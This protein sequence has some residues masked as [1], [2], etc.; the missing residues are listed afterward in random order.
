MVLVNYT[1]RWPYTSDAV[2]EVIETD[3]EDLKVGDIV[4]HKGGWREYPLGKDEWC[5]KTQIHQ[6]ILNII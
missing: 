1:K 4:V 2:G 5:L 3:R 6:L